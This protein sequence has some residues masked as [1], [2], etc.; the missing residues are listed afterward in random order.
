MVTGSC[1]SPRRGTDPRDRARYMAIA[2]DEKFV[3]LRGKFGKHALLVISMFFGWYL[4]YV[5]ASVFARDL[6]DHRLVGHINVALV[7]GVLQFA[8][9][10]VIAWRYARYSREVLDPL[11]AQI[12]ADAEERAGSAAFSQTGGGR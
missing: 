9:T 10:F 6:M 2:Q 7:F 4:L 8:S 1:P 12:V 3:L 5:M 11:T